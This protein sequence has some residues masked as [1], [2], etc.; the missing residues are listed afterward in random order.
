[1][2]RQTPAPQPLTVLHLAHPST[3]GVARVVTDLVRAQTRAGV[4]AVV[5]CPAEGELPTTAREAGARVVPW[6]TR[7]EPG[8]GMPRE[9]LEASRL[10]DRWL[11]HLAHLHG[12]RAGLA[13]RLAVRGRLPTVYQPHGWS[14]DTA[15][16]L[17]SA[18]TLGWERFATRWADRVLCVSEGERLHGRSQQV[19]GCWTVIRNGV[20]LGRFRYAEDGDRAEAR[21][22]LRRHHGIDPRAPLAVCVGRLCPQKGQDLLL[23]AWST[24]RTRLP[25]AY[26]ALVGDG[27]DRDALHGARPSRVALVPHTDEPELWYTAADLV[28]S[29]SRWEGMA[30]VPLEAM[31]VGRPVLLTDVAGARESLPAELR[32]SCLVPPGQ[33]A[34]LAGALTTLLA[35]P[36]RLAAL[37]RTGHQHVRAGF[38]VDRTTSAVLRLY[39]DL[40]ARH[41]PTAPPVEE[42]VR[43]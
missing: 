25:E 30:L 40:L 23:E 27:P 12:V 10:V 37:G 8:P 19:R 22:R 4:H 18:L 5:A 33:P 39:H 13:G 9:A 3:G 34:A 2:S 17:T 1:M 7:R 16:G 11:P 29:A 15:P 41:A 6:A 35:D 32:R 28:V 43:P 21:A 42:G 26:L 24:V 14:F 31:A 38:A 20:D 36:G